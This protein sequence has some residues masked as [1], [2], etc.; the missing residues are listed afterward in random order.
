MDAVKD[1]SE[2]IE[3]LDQC[4]SVAVFPHVHADGD[5]I[6]SAYALALVLLSRG[7]KVLVCLEEEPDSM[8]SFLRQET[9]STVVWSSLSQ[10]E[11]QRI[12]VPDLAVAV[13]CSDRARLAGRQAFFFQAAVTVKIDHHDISEDYAQYNICSVGWAAVCEGIWQLFQAWGIPRTKEINQCIYTGIL[14]DTGCFAY[15][16]TTAETH[17]IA[18]AILDGQES[19]HWIYNRIFESKT[20]SSLALYGRAYSRIQYFASG[21]I[22]FLQITEQDFAET[23]ALPEDLE[24]LSAV[25]RGIQGVEAAAL[26]KPGTRPHEWRVSLRSKSF[27]DVA[28]VAALFGGGGHKKAAGFLYEGD[29]PKIQPRLLEELEKA[30]VHGCDSE[31]I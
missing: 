11:L 8:I 14:T 30:V 10:D 19:L 22:S 5:A 2:I 7:K 17:R 25:L 16:N 27:C 12:A 1:W 21:R 28:A 24:G 20:A 29:F 31:C 13:D 9:V 23:G 4:S 18:A 6:G 26:V 3:K 15:S